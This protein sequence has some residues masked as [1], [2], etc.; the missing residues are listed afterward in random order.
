MTT[1]VTKEERFTDRTAAINFAKDML[2]NVQIIELDFTKFETYDK[3]VDYR[4]SAKY[5]E[6]S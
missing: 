6:V 5:K 1:T 4:V 2:D 3:K